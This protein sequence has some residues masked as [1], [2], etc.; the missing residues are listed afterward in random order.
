MFPNKVGAP[1]RTDKNQNLV[2]FALL[3]FLPSHRLLYVAVAACPPLFMFPMT[4][5]CSV[6]QFKCPTP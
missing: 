2:C 5:Q 4:R 6:H 1:Q 3:A